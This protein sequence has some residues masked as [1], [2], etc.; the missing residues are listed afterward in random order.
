VTPTLKQLIRALREL[1][2]T[3]E[4]IIRALKKP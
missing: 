4:Q 3:D 1:G 2:L